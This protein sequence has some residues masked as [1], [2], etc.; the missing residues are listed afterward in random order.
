[1]LYNYNMS[2]KLNNNSL[3][4]SYQCGRSGGSSGSPV[5][6]NAGNTSITPSYSHSHVGG[7]HTFGGGVSVS[8]SL[9]NGVSLNGSASSYAVSNYGGPHRDN[10]VTGGI[11]FR[12]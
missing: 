7:N 1:V 10:R 6:F 2:F 9:S 11:N 4:G 3:S 8:H 12:F 5:T